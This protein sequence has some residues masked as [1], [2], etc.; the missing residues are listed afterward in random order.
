MTPIWQTISLFSTFIGVDILSMLSLYP[1]AKHI[2][3]CIFV[4]NGCFCSSLFLLSF[5]A[6][7]TV[8]QI[9]GGMVLV[10]LAAHALTGQVLGGLKCDWHDVGGWRKVRTTLS[11]HLPLW[12]N[13]EDGCDREMSEVLKHSNRKIWTTN[14]LKKLNWHY[15]ARVNKFFKV[16]LF[17]MF[18]DMVVLFISPKLH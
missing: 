7:W 3:T 6:I 5:W 1:E 10:G 14:A 15:Y 9:S 11:W 4:W 8:V 17:T 16:K 13:V 2:Q 12:H 18:F